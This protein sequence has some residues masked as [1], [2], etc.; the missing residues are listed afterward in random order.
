M[1]CMLPHASDIVNLKGNILDSVAVL[2]QVRLNLTQ[3]TAVLFGHMLVGGDVMWPSYWGSQH[4]ASVP[5]SNNIGSCQ[6][7]S[8]FWSAVSNY[9]EAK[10]RDEVGGC[11]TGIAKIPGDIVEP[12]VVWIDAFNHS[13]VGR[14]FRW[15]AVDSGGT[16]AVQIVRS[17]NNDG[18]ILKR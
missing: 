7:R 2:D 16:H 15:F 12:C 17:K 10:V 1:D 9:P 8:G 18:G 4:K 3:Q 13:Q 5:V 14:N 6:V 11:L